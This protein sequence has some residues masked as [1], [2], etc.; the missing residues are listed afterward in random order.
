LPATPG[1]PAEFSATFESRMMIGRSLAVNT[2]PPSLLAELPRIVA[3]VISKLERPWTDR[4]PP[5]SSVASLSATSTS[6]S[7]NS[8]SPSL[9]RP[10]DSAH[11]WLP[12]IA[13]LLTPIL[14]RSPTLLT[15]P[16][17]YMPP[18]LACA[19]LSVI[20]LRLMVTLPPWL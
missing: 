5:A 3:R 13:L 17:L 18:P 8:P 1:T 14:L 12:E 6:V 20:V 11:A 16:S 4:P 7:D 19:M 9:C 15:A 2:P 10:P